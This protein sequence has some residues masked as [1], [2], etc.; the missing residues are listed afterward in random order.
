MIGNSGMAGPSGRAGNKIPKGYAEGQMQQF[1]P[2]QMK[3]FQQMFGQVGPQSYLSKLAGGDQEMFNQMEAPAMRQFGEMQADTASRFS[4]MGMGGRRSSGFQNTMSQS[5][6]NF[7][8]DLASRRQQLQQGAMMD[9]HNMSNQLLGQRP[10]QN[11]MYQ[12]PNSPSGFQSFLQG[13]LPL[14]GAAAGAAFGGPMGMSMGAQLGSAAG[15]AFGGRQA[16]PMN[17][18][19][20]SGMPTSWGTS[21]TPGNAL[22]GAS[23]N[24]MGMR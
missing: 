23:G 1:T 21:P 22:S 7:A 15:S 14:A 13:A 12:K 10:Y 17:F 8:Q 20:M 11:F 3:L 19:G 5:G 18:Q 24:F 6:S 4:G 2:N 9:L 16:Q